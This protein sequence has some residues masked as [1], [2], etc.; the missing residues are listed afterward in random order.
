MFFHT[1]IVLLCAPLISASFNRHSLT[2][3]TDNTD[4]I[5]NSIDKS[6]SIDTIHSVRIENVLNSLVQSSFPEL[7]DTEIRL[8]T[9]EEG[10]DSTVFFDSKPFI[11]R[12]LMGKNKHYRIRYIPAAFT[13]SEALSNEALYGVLAHELS[14]IVHYKHTSPL[15]LIGI[16]IKTTNSRTNARFERGTDIQTVARGYG[17]QLRS[18]RLWLTKVLSTNEVEQKFQTY[19]SPNEVNLVQAALVKCPKVYD[20]WMK[21]AP[22]NLEEIKD[23]LN[24]SNCDL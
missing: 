8:E 9:L 6:N 14:H 19:L 24:R 7:S 3:G 17:P 16:G 15:G 10:A 18:Y 21:R 20:S 11:K 13:M 5:D 22:L 1:L 12:K 4:S 23:S 2:G